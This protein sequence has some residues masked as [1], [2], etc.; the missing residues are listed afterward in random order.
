M[1]SWPKRFWVIIYT[2]YVYGLLDVVQIHVR[3]LWLRKLI[4]LLP[5]SRKYRKLAPA[6]RLR[7]ALESL[8]PIFVKFGQVLSTRPDLLS[9]DYARE[10]AMLQDRVPP[11]SS[12][13]AIKVI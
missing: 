13:I 10:L 5:S 8:G 2:V 6:V 3:P 12:D 7:L 9:E 11:F 1:W 4:R